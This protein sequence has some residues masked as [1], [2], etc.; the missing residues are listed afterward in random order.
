M[1]SD[2]DQLLREI[3]AASDSNLKSQLT[4][5]L[6]QLLDI[7]KSQG[8]QIKQLRRDVRQLSTEKKI[9]E[10]GAAVRANNN[11]TDAD[12]PEIEAGQL[13]DKAM[14]MLRRGEPRSKPI[15][16]NDIAKAEAAINSG[17]YPDKDFVRRV[18]HGY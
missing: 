7:T 15:T 5:A 18:V 17:Q 10:A 8:S 2:F 6:S 14:E 3:G 9:E 12:A 4:K 13:L 16:G 11:A 1:P